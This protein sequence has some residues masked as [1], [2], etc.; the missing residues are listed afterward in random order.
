MYSTDKGIPIKDLYNNT[1][2]SKDDQVYSNNG[3]ENNSILSLPGEIP[4][5]EIYVRELYDKN[6]VTTSSGIYPTTPPSPE[7]LKYRLLR[8]NNTT[9]D[10]IF[11]YYRTSGDSS[12]KKGL[13]EDI[14][15]NFVAQNNCNTNGDG[16]DNKSWAI[17]LNGYV[18]GYVFATI[19]SGENLDIILPLC[20]TF[21]SNLDASTTP[22]SLTSINISFY[23]N[24]PEVLCDWMSHYMEGTYTSNAT[25]FEAGFQYHSNDTVEDFVDLSVIPGG[26]C[27][28]HV[29]KYHPQTYQIGAKSINT[30]DKNGKCFNNKYA[31]DLSDQS[32]ATV[33]GLDY[34]T[35]MF[36][37]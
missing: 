22:F 10:S 35:N 25:L 8:I 6:K 33:C 11:L 28:G 23:K 20:K 31:I 5:Y 24:I 15:W 34:T 19:N 14:N 26:S 30:A 12:F 4:G 13:S 18:N 3:Y 9:K 2:Y 29:N 1:T 17:P 37:F 16:C 32:K 36:R 7:S 21:D 27:G